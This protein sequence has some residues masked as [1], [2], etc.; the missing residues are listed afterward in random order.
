MAIL[1][2][3]TLVL[4]SLLESSQPHMP[5]DRIEEIIRRL[6]TYGAPKETCLQRL[7]IL[8]VAECGFQLSLTGATEV[9]VAL[10]ILTAHMDFGLENS[11]FQILEFFAGTRRISR[12]ATS[13]G[14]KAAAHDVLYDEGNAHNINSSSGFVL[15][16]KFWIARVYVVE[17]EE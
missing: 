7:C 15:G 4:G 16:T 2:R 1:L 14:L 13:V 3:D 12:L 10:I 11:E 5:R 6:I 9:F 8:R 17:P